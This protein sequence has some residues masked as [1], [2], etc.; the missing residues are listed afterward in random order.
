M[1][2]DAGLTIHAGMCEAPTNKGDGNVK[3]NSIAYQSDTSALWGRREEADLGLTA[4]QLVRELGDR[5]PGRLTDRGAVGVEVI[6]KV[7]FATSV[8]LNA[9]TVSNDEARVVVG[10][11]T[12]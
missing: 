7:D 3:W 6:D 8:D 5:G 11:W 1:D 2:D 4:A 12:R 9:V 10:T